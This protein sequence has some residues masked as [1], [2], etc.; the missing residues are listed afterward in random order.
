MTGFDKIDHASLT[1]VGIR[2]S[3]NQDSHAVLAASDPARWLAQ[4]NFFLVADGMG[5][6]AVGE[7]ASKLAVDNILHAYS[8][9]AQ[10]DPDVALRRAFTEAN[11]IIHERGQQNPEFRGM[12]TTGT[13]ILLRR[14]EAWVGHVGDSRAYRVR[15]GVIAQLSHDHSMLWEQARR[16]NV[17]PSEVEDVPSNVILRSLG[18][19]A[20]VQVDVEGPFQVKTGDV[21]VV[22]S[23]GLSGPVQDDE[24]GS[25]AAAL[26]P[27]EA[28]RF[29][30]DLANLRGGPDNITVIVVKVLGTSA[31]AR[32]A[33]EDWEK[34]FGEPPR[35][36]VPVLVSGLIVAALALVLLIVVKSL[37]LAVWAFAAAAVALLVGLVRVVTVE[38]RYD[39]AQER[40]ASQPRA[41]PT[42]QRPCP[43]DKGLVGRLAKAVSTLQQQ[44]KEKGW[45][46]DWR[47]FQRHHGLAET[48][49]KDGDLN[50]AFREYSRAMRPLAEAAGEHRQKEEVFM[51]HWDVGL[52]KR[53]A[54]PPKPQLPPQDDVPTP[55]QGHVRPK[56]AKPAEDTPEDAAT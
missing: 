5:A 23:D 6:H 45:P 3:H 49:L 8:K 20:T 29:L 39:R 35:W 11:T 4:G 19:E 33:M 16:R 51:P 26:P 12:G 2:R 9:Y 46:T 56:A 31:E 1:D 53:K 27:A 7:L 24:I 44:I 21:Y 17:D 40:L 54:E 25:I 55:P 30:V 32:G 42:R 36:G 38:Y 37:T 14:D 15:D 50:Q 47:A 10:D 52:P 22:C 48:L 18:P 13:G 34:K 28:C 43:V 41:K